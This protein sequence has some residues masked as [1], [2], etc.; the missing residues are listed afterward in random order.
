MLSLDM[1]RKEYGSYMCRR[2]INRRFSSSLQ[3]N[4]CMYEPFPRTCPKCGKVH[5]IVV[6]LSVVGHA[7]MLFK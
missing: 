5:N 1:V 7:K 6:G 4:D 3:P 2:C